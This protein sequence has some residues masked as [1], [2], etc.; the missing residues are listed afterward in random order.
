MRAV[1]IIT[2]SLAAGLAAA[3]LS[4]A[5]WAQNADIDSARYVVS[6]DAITAVGAVAG[7]LFLVIAACLFYLGVRPRRDRDVGVMRPSVRDKPS[8]PAA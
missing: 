5:V 3:F 8:A 1:Q 7:A 4:G 6:G 2:G